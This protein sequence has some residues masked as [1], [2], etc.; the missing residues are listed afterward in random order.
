MRITTFLAVLFLPGMALAQNNGLSAT[1]SSAGIG[2]EITA[3]DT[4]ANGGHATM[5]GAN[6][7]FQLGSLLRAEG[8]YLTGTMTSTYAGAT[9]DERAH[10][11]EGEANLG[12][13]TTDHTRLFIGGGYRLLQSDPYP[14]SGGD[15]T[16]H[17]VYVP[18]GL[19][20]HGRIS[21][22][23]TAITT[24]A[25]GLVLYGRED[26]ENPLLS[27]DES[28]DRES[29]WMARASVE[30]GRSYAIGELSIEPFFRYYNLDKTDTSGGFVVQ[31]I[32]ATEGGVRFNYKL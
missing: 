20:T 31:G 22:N 2:A 13:A 7:H 4:T 17:T 25:G 21:G 24:L 9:T 16:S 12:F 32:E 11:I 3:L 10:L 1:S 27:V 5:A 6:A 14:G 28:F 29:G 15:R 19:A 8:R 18:A 26:I 30:F 23:W